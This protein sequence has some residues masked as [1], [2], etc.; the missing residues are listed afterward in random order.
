MPRSPCFSS[1]DERLGFPELSSRPIK[2]P[3]YVEVCTYPASDASLFCIIPVAWP[4][5]DIY[6][7]RDR[8]PA[9][10]TLSSICLSFYPP[11][12]GTWNHAL[13][14]SQ[15]L[16]WCLCCI[17]RLRLQPLRIM[18]RCHRIFNIQRRILARLCFAYVANR[19]HRLQR[20]D[21]AAVAS[22]HPSQFRV[23]SSSSLNRTE[24]L[25]NVRFTT[26]YYRT[27]HVGQHSYKHLYECH[28]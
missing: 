24:L 18:S 6:T 17:A 7:P 5:D 16:C 14:I 13:S 26:T 20:I 15:C 25:Y 22:A 3:T 12:A 4:T 27:A 23:S 19:A 1:L 10:L 28:V 2:I 9:Q 21:M 8:P 11:F